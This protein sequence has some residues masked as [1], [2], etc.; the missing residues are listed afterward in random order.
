MGGDNL[1]ASAGPEINR[2]AIYFLDGFLPPA[3]AG[4]RHR[5]ARP[6]SCP[7]CSQALWSRTGGVSI[8][9][10]YQYFP[11]KEAPLVALQKRHGMDR[12]CAL[13][14]LPSEP[15]EGGLHE[16]VARLVRAAV[17]AHEVAPAL[18]R[19]RSRNCRFSRKAANWW[20]RTCTVMCWPC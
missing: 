20:A 4:Q 3:Q 1:S 18:H 17:A 13:G 2:A 12:A 19:V 11:G 8:G 7:G 16:A 5:P 9:S 6:P 15:G 10:P 14:T